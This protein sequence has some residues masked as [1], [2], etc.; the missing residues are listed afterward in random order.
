[1]KDWTKI[2]DWRTVTKRAELIFQRWLEAGL[3][4]VGDVT[5]V[6]NAEYNYY[7]TFKNVEDAYGV[8]VGAVDMDEAYAAAQRVYGRQKIDAVTIEYAFDPRAYPKGEISRH[9]LEG[10]DQEEVVLDQ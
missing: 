10:D 6:F 7:V 9:K 2:D 8:I 5:R 4:S 3:L 1:M